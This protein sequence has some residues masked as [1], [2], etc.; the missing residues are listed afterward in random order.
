M[1]FGTSNM[2]KSNRRWKDKL[3]G[4]SIFS[5]SESSSKWTEGCAGSAAVSGS[6]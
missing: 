4:L 3:E 1:E 6:E 5:I 2:I